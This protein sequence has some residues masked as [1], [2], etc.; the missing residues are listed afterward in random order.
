MK[1]RNLF[2][3]A[4]AII[5]LAGPARSTRGEEIQWGAAFGLLFLTADSGNPAVPVGDAALIGHFDSSFNFS[6]N[7]TFAQLMAGFQQYNSASTIGT[8]ISGP[9]LGPGGLFA[10]TNPPNTLPGA[11][12]DQVY[13]WVFNNVNPAA[14]TEWALVTN[15]AWVRPPTGATVASYD[16]ADAGTI[17]VGPI[18]TIDASGNVIL[19]FAPIPEPST[20]LL[21]VLGGGAMIGMIRRRRML[22]AN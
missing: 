19:G 14:A 4:L 2:V 10:S 11:A 3:F 1:P 13:F 20:I 22:T 9:S 8:N 5:S 15:P 6:L 7:T 18:T 17:A 16:I 12:G 21:G